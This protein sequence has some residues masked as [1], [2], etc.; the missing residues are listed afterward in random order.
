MPLVLSAEF[1]TS[2]AL[3]ENHQE[4]AN[5]SECNRYGSPTCGQLVQIARHCESA[6]WPLTHPMRLLSDS[7]GSTV[8][9]GEA[10]ILPARY[11]LIG[12]DQS[13]YKADECTNKARS[14]SLRLLTLSIPEHHFIMVAHL[15]HWPLVEKPLHRVQFPVAGE[16]QNPAYTAGAGGI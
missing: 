3:C 7:P 16:A 5:R 1:T 9:P 8:Q 15:Y 13:G 14:L 11:Q 12:G 2:D 6:K 10:P 4:I